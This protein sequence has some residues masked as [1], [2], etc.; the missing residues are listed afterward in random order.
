MLAGGWGSWVVRNEGTEF[1]LEL[2]KYSKT[3]YI[4]KRY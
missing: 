1:L 2:M 4:K 3:E